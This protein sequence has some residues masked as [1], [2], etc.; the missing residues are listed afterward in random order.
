[1]TIKLVIT[2]KS[3]GKKKKEHERSKRKKRSY[4]AED[5]RKSWA[6]VSQRLW[7]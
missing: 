2:R 7:S 4:Q 6:S 3:G 5:G 1:M